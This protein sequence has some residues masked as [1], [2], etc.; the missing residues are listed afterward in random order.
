MLGQLGTIWKFRHFWMSLVTM[1]LRTRY[2][3]S[4]LGVGWSLM[5]PL[6][7]TVVF[8]L[9]FSSWFHNPDWRYYGPYFLSGLTLFDF[10]R[11][12]ALNG[13]QTFFRNESYIRQC[14]LPLA[15]YT[16][17]TVLGAGIHFLIALAVVLTTVFVL[18][19]GQIIPVLQ[20]SWVLAPSLV[21]LFLFAWAVSILSSFMTVYFQDSQQILEVLFQVFFF[22]TPIMYPP[23]II[24]DRGLGILLSL[25]PVY[26]F[27][28]LI[29]MPILTGEIPSAWAFSKALIV[30]S[31]FGTMAIA[32][33]AWLEKKLIFHL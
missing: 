10:V 23:E 19:P 25:N 27:F 15:V 17:R 13:C 26:T 24:L 8:C 3:R 29:R 28:E 5:N 1:D 14:P 16:L 31:L 11:S 12:T 7:M 21:L 9:V 33:I 4:V 30:V 32:S 2:R 6:M 18:R 22:L 20:I